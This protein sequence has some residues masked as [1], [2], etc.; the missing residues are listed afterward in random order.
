[1]GYPGRYTL[2]DGDMPSG[3]S[4][5]RLSRSE[6]DEMGIASNP[7]EMDAEKFRDG[8][9]MREGNDPEEV[10]AQV[11]ADGRGA[12]V[13]IL[14]MQYADEEGART[15]ANDARVLCSTRFGLNGAVLLDG[16]V[17]VLLVPEGASLETVGSVARALLDKTDSLAPVCGP[18]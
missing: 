12:R 17:V 10:H 13:T 16:D 4:E 18:R 14:A 7:G 8:A 11:L 3:V 1:M 2:D 5:A 6:M 15:A 9:P